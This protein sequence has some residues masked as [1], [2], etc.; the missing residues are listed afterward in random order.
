MKVSGSALAAL[1]LLVAWT[2]SASCSYPSATAGTGLGGRGIFDP[3][4][5]T[6][7]G[8]AEINSDVE[9]EEDT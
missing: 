3:E 2:M 8:D 1:G 7:S 9:G 5:S 4:G 6:G